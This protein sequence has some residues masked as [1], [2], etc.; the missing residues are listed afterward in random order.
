M[1]MEDIIRL[2]ELKAVKVLGRG[3]MGTVF[4]VFD[5]KH[6]RRS[7]ALKVISKSSMVEKEGGLR[8]TEAELDILSSSLKHPFLSPFLGRLET[9]KIIAFVGEYCPGGDLNNL[10]H[11]QPEKTFSESVIR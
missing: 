5:E 7:L 2:E 10:R 3:A 6:D 9:E 1:K 11:E 4:L 8:R